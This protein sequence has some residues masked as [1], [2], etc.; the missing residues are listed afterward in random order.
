LRF[1]H[2]RGRHDVGLDQDIARPANHHQM[3][4]TVASDQD[5]APPSVDSGDIGHGKVRLAR[6]GGSAEA[7]GTK[8]ADHPRRCPEQPDNDHQCDDKPRR[9]RHVRTE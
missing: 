6:L 8:S 1:A 5:Q 9:E 4:G 2:R 7:P 3:L